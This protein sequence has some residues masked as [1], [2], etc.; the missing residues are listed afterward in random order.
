M[1]LVFAEVS[2]G[3]RGFHVHDDRALEVDQVIEPTSVVENNR[4]RTISGLPNRAH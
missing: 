3:R 2:H 1:E 4:T